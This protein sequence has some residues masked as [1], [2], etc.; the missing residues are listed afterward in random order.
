MDLND[1][2]MSLCPLAK[3]P[4]RQLGLYRFLAPGGSFISCNCQSAR[5]NSLWASSRCSTTLT[6][7]NQN[8]NNTWRAGC[9]CAARNDACFLPYLV[10]RPTKTKCSASL[11]YSLCSKQKPYFA[12]LTSLN[13]LA[14]KSGVN[15]SDRLT[16]IDIYADEKMGEPSAFVTKYVSQN[17]QHTNTGTTMLGLGCCQ[18]SNDLVQEKMGRCW[19]ERM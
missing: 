4:A 13:C 12:N 10:N 17:L 8:N 15:L 3:T 16:I 2:A 7:P 18:L 1:A 11:F 5:A 14:L 6:I 9:S 19:G